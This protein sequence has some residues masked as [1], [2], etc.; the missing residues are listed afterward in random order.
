MGN[1]GQLRIVG[2]WKVMVKENEVS[3]ENTEFVLL[4][5]VVINTQF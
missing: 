5:T 3:S 1:D 2:C 4:L